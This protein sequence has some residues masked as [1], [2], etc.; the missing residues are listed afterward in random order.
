MEAGTMAKVGIVTDTVACIPP[1]KV[2]EYDIRIIPFAL[3]INGKT[4]LDQVDIHPDEFWKM[5]KDIKE[6]TTGAPGLG[7]IMDV[8]RDLGK[9]TRDIACT[10]VSKK[11]SA[12]HEA[13]TQARELMLKEDPG[14][15][16]QIVDSTT[17]CGAEG[18]VA[19]EMARAARAGGSMA[20]VVAA[21]RQVIPR[22][23]W[24]LG[25]ETLKYLIA[26][27]RAPKV[28]YAG[29]LFGVKPVIGMVNNTGLVDNIGKARGMQ[30]CLLKLVELVRDYADTTRSLHVNAHYT[31]DIEDG[32]RLLNL[33][34]ARYNCTDVSLTTLTPVMCGHTG[35]VVGLSFIP[36]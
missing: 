36:E 22:V 24:I 16:I 7:V 4:Y 27:G 25:M 13:A 5:F 18:F 6:L 21:A 29:E 1:E 35:P 23:K 32:K 3:N 31:D 28:A 14:L 34:T 10:F 12:M 26:G 30:K 8:F 17:A 9:S 19:Q 33:V 20:D 2:R 15:N 11:I